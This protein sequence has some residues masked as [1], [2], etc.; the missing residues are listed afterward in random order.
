MKCREVLRELKSLSDPKA[1]KGMA[2][3][4]INPKNTLGVS[5]PVLRKMAQE[6]GR[7]HVLAQHLWNSQIHEARL[8]AAMIDEWI[9]VTENQME[10][11]VSDFDSWD[12]CDQCCSNLFD[13][14]SLAW[15]KAVE[16]TERKEEFVRADSC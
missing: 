7:D 4:G 11:W 6:I 16:W 8:L 9:M 15:K 14:T 5:I 2:R 12:I 3:F 1:V 13:K 10:A